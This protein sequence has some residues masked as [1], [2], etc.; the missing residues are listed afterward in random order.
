M[1]SD[2]F[3]K[4]SEL[5]NKF[6]RWFSD[7]YERIYSINI[8][9]GE[10]VLTY[11]ND[12]NHSAPLMGNYK[13]GFSKLIE[14]H[15]ADEFKNDFIK[16]FSIENLSKVFAEDA[17]ARLSLK[18]KGKA[19]VGRASWK[20]VIAKPYK[21]LASGE[22]YAICLIKDITDDKK[23]EDVC[24][25]NALLISEIEHRRQLDSQNERFEII[26]KQTD[27]DVVEWTK[28]DGYTYISERLSDM[29]YISMD[30]R[31]VLSNLIHPDDAKS[32]K[33]FLEG[34]I[35]KK[36]ESDELVCRVMKKNSEYVWL[37]ICASN[38]YD[39]DG[40]LIK[41]VSTIVDVDRPTKAYIDI[42]Y[43]ANH[44][45]LTGLRNKES[46]FEIA[47]DC[48]QA[49][50]DDDYAVIVMDIDKFSVI[51]DVYGMKTGDEVL[52]YVAEAI[53][54]HTD[55]DCICRMYSDNFAMLL[56]NKSDDSIMRI[57]DEIVDNIKHYPLDINIIVSYGIYKVEDTSLPVSMMCDWAGY[58][59]KA[60]KGNALK[61]GQFYD[62]QLRDSML[63]DQ[64]ME[65]EM[66]QALEDGQFRLYLQPKMDILTSKVIGA[67]AL[68]R[69]IHPTKGMIMPNRFIPLFEKN[70]FII[71]MDIY[72]WEQVCK[73][74]RRWIDEGKNPV[75]I[76][77]N[78]S[79]L[80]IVDPT[81]KDTLL[82]LT[83]KYDIPHE[84]L[85]IEITETAFMDQ[86][87][88]IQQCVQELKALGFNVSIDDFGSGY[89]SLNMLK[90][91]DVDT[92][93]IDRGFLNEVVATSR[94]KTIISHTIAMA[95]DL[96]LN[97]I[98]EG[99]ETVEQAEFLVKNGCRSAQGF[100][101]SKPLSIQNYEM[102]AYNT[103][104]HTPA[105]FHKRNPLRF[106]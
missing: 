20:Q 40:V 92:L 75:P 91:I 36:I 33:E 85:E 46:F 105:A 38:F 34:V 70:S 84:L 42:A 104:S 50:P 43:R 51:N 18:Y 100:L 8:K 54:K 74:L 26:V 94:G 81:L 55:D 60:I 28:D 57:M 29:F 22:M 99:V 62:E 73:V 7:E 56:K 9:T 2:V 53:K 25:Q 78:L 16:M 97:V 52:C 93:K 103:K 61:F 12:E 31:G 41:T 45:E 17:H 72:L 3:I 67:E 19:E 58:A 95:N 1:S 24:M 13:T 23:Y 5:M 10:Y 4:D 59:K 27:A 44:D 64:M 48:M 39:D 82:S 77:I 90:E 11:L 98:S 76:S 69:W 83:G 66:E 35:G 14:S 96:N 80:H 63:E 102:Y 21:S 87:R 68:V 86:T 47:Q 37:K 15:V 106:S 101:Y 89:S 71:R 88:T 49:N 32:Y 30:K 79:R 65:S 6:F